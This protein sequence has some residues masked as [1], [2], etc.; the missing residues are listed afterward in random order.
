MSNYQSRGTIEIK[1]AILIWWSWSWRSLVSV[2]LILVALFI[3]AKSSLVFLNIHIGKYA[4]KSAFIAVFFIICGV[5]F[6]HNLNTILGKYYDNIDFKKSSFILLSW[7]WK[8]TLSSFAV[9]AAELGF[10]IFYRFSSMWETRG[11][12]SFEKAKPIGLQVN[13]ISW[14]AMPGNL[15]ILFF[16]IW[17]L[18][19]TI[20]KYCK[21]QLISKK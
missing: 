5:I 4:P 21:C 11:I 7:L 1:K 18:K 13:I 19:I 12:A 16:S 3:L 2:F 9:L 6:V 10:G 17:F 15:I 8:F 14:G 20:S